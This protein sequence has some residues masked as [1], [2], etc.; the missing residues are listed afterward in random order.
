[1]VEAGGVK[2]TRLVRAAISV[3]VLGVMVWY[4]LP[5][6]PDFSQ[7]WG[8]VTA[9][10]PIELGLLVTLAA[11]NLVT[12]WIATVAASP[13]LTYRQAMVVKMSATAVSNAV[14]GGSALSLGVSYAMLGSWGF[15]KSRITVSMAVGG[16]WNNFVKLGMPVLALGLLA[17]TGHPDSSRILLGIV[18]LSALCGSVALFSSCCAASRS[19]SGPARG[20]AGSRPGFSPYGGDRP[21]GAG[22]TRRRSFASG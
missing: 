8:H 4:V 9:M 14:P 17:F 6:L 3:V 16:I 18:G 7:V 11:W 10:T 15:S 1:L 20:Q 12:Y 19:P 13:G 2:N 22:D 21:C 5:K